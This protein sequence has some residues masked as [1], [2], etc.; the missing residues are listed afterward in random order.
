MVTTPVYHIPDPIYL[1]ITYL[2]PINSAL[3]LVPRFTPVYEFISVVYYMLDF[4][5]R[6]HELLFLFLSDLCSLLQKICDTT[7]FDV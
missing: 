2:L 1:F 3:V 6:Y 4:R 7:Y 5:F